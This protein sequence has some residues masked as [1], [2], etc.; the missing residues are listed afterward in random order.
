M[1]PSTRSSERITAILSTVVAVA[2]LAAGVTAQQSRGALSDELDYLES[3]LRFQL[4]SAFRLNPIQGA[5]RVKQLDGVLASWREALRTQGDRKLLAAWLLEA[6]IRSM[7]GSLEA[8]PPAPQ[9]GRSEPAARQSTSS[10]PETDPLA[11]APAKTIVP[12][13]IFDPS[14]PSEPFVPGLTPDLAPPLK[15]VAG[16]IPDLAPPA[17]EHTLVSAV[18]R[19]TSPAPEPAGPTVAI[20]LT[21]LAARIAGYHRG[22]SE[23]DSTLVANEHPQLDRLAGQISVLE[24]LAQDY[25]FVR[26]YYDALTAQERRTVIPPRSLTNTLAELRRHLDRLQNDVEADFLGEYDAA[27]GEKFASLRSRLE[28]IASR[29]DW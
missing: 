26:L 5:A 6:T 3:D 15:P 9:F 2:I 14:E 7:P 13:D 28:A 10:P 1:D 23:L 22:L 20:N 4:E 18:N 19:A 16:L 8:L 12:G 25:Q 21:E 11:S 17:A 29:A 27:L 24:S